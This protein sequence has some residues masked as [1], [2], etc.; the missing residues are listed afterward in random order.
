MVFPGRE[1]LTDY[2]RLQDEDDEEDEEEVNEFCGLSLTGIDKEAHR[3]YNE[4]KK[5]EEE[6]Q[7]SLKAATYEKIKKEKEERERQELVRL[8]EKYG[9]G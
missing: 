5:K 6:R 7:A 3:R 8:K 2:R 9:N 4:M 1:L